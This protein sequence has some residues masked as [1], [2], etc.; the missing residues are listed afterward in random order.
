ML[1]VDRLPGGRRR[2]RLTR[3]TWR[4]TGLGGDRPAR[5]LARVRAGQEA[6]GETP[7]NFELCIYEAGF[8]RG[9]VLGKTGRERG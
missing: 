1:H 5:L 4:G 8:R 9:N 7:D 6:G 2:N 3:G